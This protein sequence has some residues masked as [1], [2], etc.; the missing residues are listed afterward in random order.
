MEQVVAVVVPY[1]AISIEDSW[2]G[3][4]EGDGYADSFTA[5][6]EEGPHRDEHHEHGG[7]EREDER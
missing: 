5:G 2:M 6:E 3:S 7:E 4:I 1:S